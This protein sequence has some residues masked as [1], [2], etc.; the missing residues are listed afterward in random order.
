MN[1]ERELHW[2]ILIITLTDSRGA[3]HVDSRVPPMHRSRY[4]VILDQFGGAMLPSSNT[5]ILSFFAEP[6]SAMQA[7]ITILQSTQELAETYIE[8]AFLCPRIAIDHGEAEI[9]PTV[10][11]G[12]TVQ[13]AQEMGQLA[14]ENVFLV[15]REFY[16]QLSIDH[17]ELA[18]VLPAVEA[19]P[20]GRILSGVF[21]IQWRK[22]HKDPAI[23]ETIQ[24]DLK[25]LLGQTV[26]GVE[27]TCEGKTYVC[28]EDTTPT[29]IGR[30]RDCQVVAH[31]ETASR[32]HARIE[33]EH[34]KFYL[35]DQSRNGTYVLTP[36]GEEVFLHND[37]LPLMGRGVFSLGT[38]I[39]KQGEDMVR[40][41]CLL[42][43]DAK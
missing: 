41:R 16:Q 31:S 23:R 39:S 1:D 8:T 10:A 26:V 22:S 9:T 6:A 4:A 40:Y 32:L 15:T 37:R 42:A 34:H 36:T 3:V 25:D 17:R 29:V 24:P 5:E 13:R 11:R 7:A 30:D 33:Y 43:G 21:E 12:R 35:V 19:N 27:I 2:S 14:R 38:S 20:A 18:R 28:N